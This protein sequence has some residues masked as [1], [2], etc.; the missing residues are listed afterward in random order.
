MWHGDDKQGSEHILQS[1]GFRHGQY[2]LGKT[3]VFIKDAAELFALEH[4]REIR[5]NEL[6]CL[7]QATWRNYKY[8]ARAK[9]IKWAEDLTYTFANVR[10]D[11]HFGRDIVWPQSPGLPH[12]EK[13]VKQIFENWRARMLVMS[14]SPEEQPKMRRRGIAHKFA[15]GV[16]PWCFQRDY[17]GNYIDMAKPSGAKFLQVLQGLMQQHGGQEI[18]FAHEVNKVNRY[19]FTF[20]KRMVVVTN[21]HVY[22]TNGS[23]KI[24]AEGKQIIAVGDIKGISMSRSRDSFVIIHH[25]QPGK[26]VVLDLGRAA[27]E[28]GMEL[29][30]AIFIATRDIPNKKYIDVKIDNTL[31]YNNSGKPDTPQKTLTFMDVPA[32][33][34]SNQTNGKYKSGSKGMNMVSVLQG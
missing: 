29:T 11:R 24:N 6:V 28:R 22:K 15:S 33:R 13:Y 2:Q 3:K 25:N 18:H 17:C 9:I 30:A 16:K 12:A 10:A 31:N 20:Q 1:L 34:K 27:W 4:A 32:I 21:T 23:G 8:H 26:D 7:I 5:V 19:G 14:L